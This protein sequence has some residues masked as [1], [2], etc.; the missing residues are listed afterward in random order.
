VLRRLVAVQAQDA[1]SARLA[2]RARLPGLQADAL[3]GHPVTWL[4]RGTLHLV[5]SED[6]PWLHALVPASVLTANARRL[7]QLGVE[8]SRVEDVRSALPFERGEAGTLLGLQGQAVPHLLL[9][10]SLLGVC[11]H[12]LAGRFRAVSLPRVDRDAALRELARRYLAA[13]QGADERDLAAWSGL[14]LR[15]VRRGLALAGGRDPAPPSPLNRDR[16]DS[17]ADGA[18]P[19][20]LLPAFDPYLLGWRDRTFAVPQALAAGVFPG[21]GMFRATATVDGEVTGTWSVP[22]GRV[23]LDLAAGSDPGAFAAEAADVERLLS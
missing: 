6:L 15:D 22:G 11:V 5:R 4:L 14:G 12:D 2:V 3:D 13:H 19:P 8:P 18:V 23:R 21:G 1:R 20:R 7:A 9:R 16:G 17:S 10:A